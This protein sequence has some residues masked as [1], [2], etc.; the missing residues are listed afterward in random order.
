MRRPETRALARRPWPAAR[1]AGWRTANTCA[2]AHTQR[3]S[4]ARKRKQNQRTHTQT[5][6]IF[7]LVQAC[8]KRVR[9]SIWF[10]RPSQRRRLVRDR[11]KYTHTRACLRCSK[12]ARARPI[13]INCTRNDDED[14]A[15]ARRQ[16][17]ANINIRELVSK[18][19]Q[20]KESAGKN[21]NTR[22][23]RATKRCN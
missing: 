22:K 7:R 20:S 12:L 14:V 5:V 4:T 13:R 18:A 8:A 21:Q 11:Q 15:S 1:L 3:T 16:A 2:R 19:K 17:P 23:L 10:A 9:I 6:C